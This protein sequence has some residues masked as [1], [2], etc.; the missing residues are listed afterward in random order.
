[1]RLVP[2]AA[3]CMQYN[4]D[5]QQLQGLAALFR[6]ERLRCGPADAPFLTIR[7]QLD[8]LQWNAGHLVNTCKLKE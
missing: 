2:A 1:M 3:Y 4:H 8:D 6:A 7:D 5:H